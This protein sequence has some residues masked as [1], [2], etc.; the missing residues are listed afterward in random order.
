MPRDTALRAKR[1]FPLLMTLTAAIAFAQEQAPPEIKLQIVERPNP[2]RSAEP[3]RASEVSDFSQ[4]P[5]DF[6]SHGAYGDSLL[7]N[8]FA[9]F[10]FGAVAQPGS[11][12]TPQRTG[13]ILD[14]FPSTSDPETFHYMQPTLAADNGGL[15]VMS[16]S[17]ERRTNADDGSASVFVLGSDQRLEKVAVDTTYRM[18]RGW[19]G[20][21]ASTKV[22][23]DGDKAVT[24]PVLADHIA[25]GAM[26]PF[27]SGSGFSARPGIVPDCE[28]VFGRQFDAYVLIRPESGLFEFR[29][30]G[31]HTLAVYAKDVTL[32]PG[33]SREYRRW[34]V[35]GTDDP[36][37]LFSFT[38][39]QRG[40]ENYGILAGRIHERSVLDDGRE[41]ETGIV[42]NADVRIQTVRRPDLPV[43]YTGRPYLFARTDAN[44]NFQISIPPGEYVVYAWTSTR[45]SRPS[46]IAI[47]VE[48]GGRISATDLPVSRPSGLVYEIVD[49]ETGRPVPG[50]LSFMPLRGTGDVDLGP[51][52][53]QTSGSATYSV[54]GRGSVELPPGDYRVVASRGNEFHSTERR[55]RIELKQA[56]TA[57]F[58]MRRAFDTKGW[59]AAD[60]GVMTNNS[61][62]SRTSPRTRVVTGLAEG[63]DWMVTS[64]LDTITDLR[65]AARE[66]GVEGRIA[67]S[68]GIRISSDAS[69]N[70]G[71]YLLFPIEI[72]GAG[73]N[74]SLDRVKAAKTP[75]DTIAALR[76]LCPQG[77]LVA[78]RP[79]F[80]F[81]GSL[82][83]V[84][85]DFTTGRFKDD[86]VTLPVD[87]VQ[88]WEGKR[89]NIIEQSLVAYY[90]LLAMG[91]RVAPVGNS[92]SSGTFND[93]VGYPRLY[94]ASSTD[95]PDQLEPAALS[96]AIKEGRV[97]ITNGPFM[98]L[99]ANG[100]E[101]GS[102]I[103][104]TDGTVDLKLEVFSPN[105]ASV[106]DISVNVNG[107]FSRKFILPAGS[108][109][110]E[111][112]QVF[113][114]SREDD[115][116][117][118]IKLAITKD[119]VINVVVTGDPGLLQDPVNPLSI[120]TND[121]SVPR[122]QISWAIS[123]PIYVDADGDGVVKLDFGT[124]T[125]AQEV[126]PDDT[127]PF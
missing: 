52:G 67:L 8:D 109:D 113:P 16:T 68:Q 126:Q 81:I 102:T 5:D 97:V 48:G 21:L 119:S 29:N 92:L 12:S 125:G 59:I 60:I 103:T 50:K 94:I 51:P 69:A 22:T 23:N 3:A 111:A 93:E 11:P 88:V 37:K 105:W 20:V 9:G 25:W 34:I 39:E 89:Q 56:Q 38:Q 117:G 99:T 121:P 100:S 73:A 76:A 30:E 27:A 80:P 31:T 112:G 1:I 124:P 55:V 75:A 71:E 33:E 86:N 17:I 61:P 83:A 116:K 107:A 65:P 54:T 46:N 106:S 66:L 35:T 87:A 74:L 10:I 26:M 101:I 13:S 58:E 41:V 63:L 45:E 108:V 115:E 82:T 77:V 91:N 36:S 95:A 62:H 90:N 43:E 6:W 28:F 114:S 84:G 42:A 104:D 40:R 4:L 64:D 19:P 127:A 110:P 32:N 49:A 118:R 44:G 15:S 85:Y 7:R 123:G 79:I 96:R 18:E 98:R 47:K 120:P 57:R 14:I 53:A 122:G 70:R 2:V 78:S 24:I 72:C